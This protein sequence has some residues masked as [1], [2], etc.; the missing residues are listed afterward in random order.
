MINRIRNSWDDPRLPVEVRAVLHARAQKVARA[1]ELLIKHT[2]VHVS[3]GSVIVEI[4]GHR[5]NNVC[6]FVGG[7]LVSTL[8]VE[9]VKP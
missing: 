3:V 2:D 4:H 6:L 8:A 1:A 9:E 7:L 5:I